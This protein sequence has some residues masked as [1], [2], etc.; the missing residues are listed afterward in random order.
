MKTL[1]T[2]QFQN[3]KSFLLLM[4]IFLLV[5][6]AGCNKKDSAIESLKKQNIAV[7]ADSLSGFSYKGDLAT[8]KLLLDA[9]VDANAQD[10]RESTALREASWAG[11]QEVVSYLLDAKADVNSPSSAKFTALSAAIS[12]KQVAIALLLLEHGANPNVVDSGGSTPLIE[13][14]WQGRL[15]LVKAL[16][17]KGAAQNYKRPD[18]GFTALKAAGNK[19]DIV[20]ALKAAGATE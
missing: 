8:V 9:G 10:S 5:I 2:F 14:A 15:P 18:S 4:A 12:Q 13:A 11:K 19:A 7:S 1:N 6:A 20:E 3:Y 16:L 17:P